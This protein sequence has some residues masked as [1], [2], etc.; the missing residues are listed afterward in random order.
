[1]ATERYT[2]SEVTVRNTTIPRGALVYVVLASADRD[3]AT[4][5]AAD[6]FDVERRPN[7]HLAFGHGIH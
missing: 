6:R 7:R 2:T 3:D 4:F 1:M 5:T